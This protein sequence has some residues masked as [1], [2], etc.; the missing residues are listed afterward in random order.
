MEVEYIN[1]GLNDARIVNFKNVFIIIT[2]ELVIIHGAGKSF[3]AK[4]INWI[5]FKVKEIN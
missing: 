1:I 2:D 5:Y 3:E 4:D